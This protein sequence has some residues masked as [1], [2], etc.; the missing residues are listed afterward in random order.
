MKGS[1][2]F[3]SRKQAIEFI[4]PRHYAGRVPQISYSFGW[5]IQK[6]L[7]AVCTIG[8]PA[9]P[10][11]CVGICGEEYSDMVME[12][13]RLIRLPTLTEPLSQF[14]GAVLRRLICKN[15][16][17]VSYSD[18]AMNHNGY[19]YQA[20][21][22]IY[23]GMTKERTDKSGTSGHS[24]HYEEDSPYRQVRSSKH[25]YIYFCTRDKRLKKEWIAALSYPVDSYP[26]GENKNYVLGETL[27]TKRIQVADNTAWEEAQ[28]KLNRQM[29]LED[30]ERTEE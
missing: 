3:I 15:I 19:I 9:S 18:T 22:F 7:V 6:E 11:L 26:K 4:M 23:T 20:C 30:I 29:R 27:K 13:N 21:N 12:L 5:V 16:I 25:R 8:K 14:V 2:E 28:E 1:V 10:S 24:R 17:L